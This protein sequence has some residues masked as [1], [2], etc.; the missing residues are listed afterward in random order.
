[1]SRISCII[2]SYNK[3]KFLQD[4]IVSVLNQTRPVAEIIVADDGSTDGSRNLITSLAQ[5]YCKI[6]PIFR[7]KNLG[8]AANRDLAIREANGDLLTTLDGDDWYS[9]Q[10]IEKEL[11]AIQN[12]PDAIAYSDVRLVNREGKQISEWDISGFSNFDIAQRLRWLSHRIGPIPRDM[13]LPKKLYLEVLGMRHC[14]PIYEDWDFKI[15]LAAYPNEWIHSGIA[16]INYR[17]TKSGLSQSS[18]L[19][20]TKCQYQVLMANQKLLKKYLGTQGFWLAIAKVILKAGRSVARKVIL[21][22]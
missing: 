8:V 14:L 9:P 13:L 7:E 10:K 22:D 21:P 16:G 1:M 19:I 17:K 15:R 3:G 11:I 2:V 5:E 20:H 4:A 18:S 12:K 6:K